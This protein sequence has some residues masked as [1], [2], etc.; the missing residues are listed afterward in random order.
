MHYYKL[1][2]KRFQ[3]YN[4]LEIWLW[5]IR[6][7]DEYIIDR[8]PVATVCL[9]TVAIFSLG[10]HTST[11]VPISISVGNEQ[12]NKKTCSIF[13]AWEIISVAAKSRKTGLR[14]REENV[15]TGSE[16]KTKGKRSGNSRNWKN[17]INKVG[18]EK[19]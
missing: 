15:L 9:A 12:H 3:R 11:W 16:N 2:S 1:I 10:F 18:W 17:N 8:V 6:N 13:T 7:N 4:T 19:W 5:T 14:T